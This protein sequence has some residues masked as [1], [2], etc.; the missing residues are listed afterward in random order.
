MHRLG[1]A[2]WVDVAARAPAA[3]LPAGML[4]AAGGTGSLTVT[5]LLT[6]FALIGLG[7][8]VPSSGAA[9]DRF[10]QRAVLLATAALHVIL[11][12]L[13]L[14]VIPAL[15]AG[16]REEL[17]LPLLATA[18]ALA[19]L[20]GLTA[21]SVSAMNRTRGWHLHRRRPEDGV[22]AGPWMRREAAVDELLLV[23]SPLLVGLL[24]G[25]LGVGAGLMLAA[26]LG[27]LAVPAYVMDPLAVE[28]DAAQGAA[29][30][31]LRTQLDEGAQAQGQMSPEDDGPLEPLRIPL[32]AV[33]HG[34]QM[35]AEARGLSPERP[36]EA[37]HPVGPYGPAGS[38]LAGALVVSLGLG[39]LI[40]ASAVTALILA[41]D[42]HRPGAAGLLLG[43]CGAAGML[44]SRWLP[45]R[46][47]ALDVP[48]RRRLFAVLLALCAL[49]LAGVL[50]VA[51][52]WPG[53]FVGVALSLTLFF[54]LGASLGV[55]LVEVYRV[56]AR[57]APTAD[58]VSTLSSVAGALL[59][60]LVVGLSAAALLAETVSHAWAAAVGVV[61]ATVP[62]AVA[63]RRGP[64]APTAQGSASRTESL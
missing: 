11:L 59:V 3:L 51:V 13:L 47:T 7:L 24:S 56:V 60:G 58:L 15:D 12:V 43:V 64:S 41:E 53:G 39:L 19:L 28:L 8:S 55:L 50:A 9:A 48:R 14:A 46:F 30:A 45:A 4:F 36:G 35:V 38:S 49:L 20:A 61:G 22:A 34:Q 52:T 29:R 33:E 25:P 31:Q 40:G 17:S 6:S 16:P 54:G 42:A 18:M 2:G 27:A 37:I 21:P 5:A 10:G 23:F 26:L 44:S 62:A 63:L 57:R 32:P 1:P